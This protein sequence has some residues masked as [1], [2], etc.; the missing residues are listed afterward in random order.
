[1]GKQTCTLSVSRECS[2][3][4]RRN[5]ALGKELD[6]RCDV[7]FKSLFSKDTPESRGALCYLLS[8]V[9]GQKVENAVVVNGETTSDML[10]QKVIRM[11]IKCRFCG[12]QLADI[13]MQKKDTGD[14]DEPRKRMNYYNARLMSGQLESGES[15]GKI[16]DCHQIT[17]LDYREFDDE[18]YYHHIRQYDQF[19]NVY[20]GGFRLHFFELTKLKQL[21][22]KPVEE[23]SDAEICAIF[24]KYEGVPEYTDKLE[25]IYKFQEG[26]RMAKTALNKMS[27]DIKEWAQQETRFRYETDYML[28]QIHQKHE[29][30]KAVKKG[31]EEGLRQGLEQGREEGI[32]D[33]AKKMKDMNL[34]SDTII[35]V[36]GLS[37][38]QIEKL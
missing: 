35:K 15:A 30:E 11:D 9:T 7:V 24:L 4:I 1:M 22:E 16:A 3:R 19:L 2:D 32:L 25:K 8:A 12:G 13:E 34:P 18:Q 6:I 5:I 23:L 10:S 36:T 28:A 38:E 37:P 31:L 33:T 17:F 29:T 21:M 14:V 27:R 26:V 20:D